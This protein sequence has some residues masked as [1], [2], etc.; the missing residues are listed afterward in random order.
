MDR[1]AVSMSA[2]RLHLQKGLETK[3]KMHHSIPPRVELIA[4][5]VTATRP[6]SSRH[7]Q[8][9]TDPAHFR[10]L[11]NDPRGPFC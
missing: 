2:E 10:S 3:L 11:T 8:P 1:H 9:Y 6:E 5:G 4:E 7:R